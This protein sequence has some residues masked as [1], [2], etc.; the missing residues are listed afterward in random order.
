MVKT[1]VLYKKISHIRHNLDR[2]VAKS[3]MSEKDFLKNE[4]AQES[5]LLNL[6]QAIQGCIDIGSHIISGEG[7]GAPGSISDIFYRLEEH[8]IIKPDLVETIIPMAGFRNLIVHQYQD[9]D[10]KIVYQLYQNRL[11]DIEAFLDAVE[12]HFTP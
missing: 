7:W 2:L 6:Q 8:G 11:H 5:V 1:S 4:D 12:S 10:F 9:V 3:T